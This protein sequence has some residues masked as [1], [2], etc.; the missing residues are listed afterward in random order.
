[1]GCAGCPRSPEGAPGAHKPRVYIMRLPRR[2]NKIGLVVSL[3]AARGSFMEPA[4]YVRKQFRQVFRNQAGTERVGCLAM[5]PNS[6][7][8]SLVSMH[9]LGQKS[10]NY[11]GQH[12]ARPSG[13]QPRRAFA[14]IAARPSGAAI[15][16]SA[17]L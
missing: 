8:C 1:M 12:I 16:V 4:Q 14:L 11:A 15:T 6:S 3:V 10:A 5:E 13:R 7:T 9:A 2:T 17:P